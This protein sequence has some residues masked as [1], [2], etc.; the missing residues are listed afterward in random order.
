MQSVPGATFE[1]HTVEYT[2]PGDSSKR[3]EQKIPFTIFQT[4]KTRNVPVAMYNAVCSWIEKNPEYTYHFYDDDR[5][6]DY[7]KNDFPCEDFTFSKETLLRALQTIRPG[8][9]KADLFR[10]LIMYEKGGVYMDIDTVCLN[11]LNSFMQSDD[12]VLTGI[13][14]RGDFHQWG[15]IYP[16]RHPFM[17]RAVENRYPPSGRSVRW[18]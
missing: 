7:I 9:G 10:Y 13:G 14:I 11:A 5:L 18:P 15:L 17:K 8:A 4:F 1:Q 3:K 6:F 12:E 2:Y 16:D